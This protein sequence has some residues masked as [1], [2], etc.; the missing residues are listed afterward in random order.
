MGSMPLGPRRTFDSP[1]SL[2]YG[3][4]MRRTALRSRFN[5]GAYRLLSTLLLTI[6]SG[7][8]CSTTRIAVG[9]MKPIL[10]AAIDATFRDSDWATACE[11]IP[12]NLLLV[13]GLCESS[14]GD[15]ELHARA[16]Q[17]YFS[18]GLGFIEDTDPARAALLYSEGMRLGRAALQERGWFTRGEAESSPSVETLLGM[19][20]DDVPL[21]FWTL[22]NWSSW[23]GQRM[24]SPE[25]VAQLPRVEAYLERL[26]ELEPEYFMGM[27]HV[28]RGSILCL[29]PVLFG[30][31]PEQGRKHF[32]EGFR[33]SGNR[34]LLFHVLYAQ[35]YCRATLD[36]SEFRRRLEEVRDAPSDILPEYRLLNEVA[37]RKAAYLLEKEHELF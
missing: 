16:A 27:P 13:R 32:E 19:N 11:A 10:G 2:G 1:R 6:V 4:A 9:S 21:L 33:I 3:A 12:A 28:L 35:Y 20:R 37:K 17:L 31:N 8:G 14:P 25:I 7:S 29:R 30:G 15:R 34:L 26:L 18:Y 22:C 23:V 24:D 5:S 36:Q